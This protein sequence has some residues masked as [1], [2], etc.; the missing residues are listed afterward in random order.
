MSFTV[1]PCMQILRNRN[2]QYHSMR[3][4][5]DS[6]LSKAIPDEVALEQRAAALAKRSAALRARRR[7]AQRRD[8]VAALLARQRVKDPVVKNAL[9]LRIPHSIQKSSS[10]FSRAG[11]ESHA[12]S[13]FKNCLASAW[14]ESIFCLTSVVQASRFS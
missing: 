3:R 4:R 7:R 12:R 9:G 10:T 1:L 13:C 5:L 2:L 8:A 6:I 14:Q 11:A